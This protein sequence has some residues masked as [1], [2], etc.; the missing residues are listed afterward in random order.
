VAARV[1]GDLADSCGY[2]KRITPFG[3]VRR[4]RGKNFPENLFDREKPRLKL[5]KCSWNYSLRLP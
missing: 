1:L 5:L 3:L 4:R 2:R